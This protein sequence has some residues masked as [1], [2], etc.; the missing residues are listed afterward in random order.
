[1]FKSLEKPIIHIYVPQYFS[2]IYFNNIV[3][4]MQ[5]P[6]FDTIIIEFE[7]IPPQVYC[8]QLKQIIME[9]GE[10]TFFIQPPKAFKKLY[11]QNVLLSLSVLVEDVVT[12]DIDG[13]QV[14]FIL[15]DLSND[16]TTFEWNALSEF[17]KN[18]PQISFFVSFTVTTGNIRLERSSFI[19]NKL[20]DLDV[21]LFM[22]PLFKET[23]LVV[24]HPCNA[25]LCSEKNC[26]G[27]KSSYPKYLYFNT[28]GA[29]PYMCIDDRI[30]FFRDISLCEIKDVNREFL[31][32]KDSVQHKV[33]IACNKA[34][35]KTYI[36]PRVSALFAWNIMLQHTLE[37]CEYW[38][39]RY[40]DF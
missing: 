13:Y 5:H 33:F 25:Y 36:L 6:D 14:V 22:T 40:V 19:L 2:N 26:H 24:E 11:Y 17:I 3:K 31:K 15:F 10:K 8:E 1:M 29:Y 34:I 37:S 30:A 12:I 7:S 39:D 18:H 4:L 23:K 9:N 32:Y 35:F 20:Y 38:E 16:Y 27:E 21:R 28:S